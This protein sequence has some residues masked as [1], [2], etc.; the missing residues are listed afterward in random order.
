MTPTLRIPLAALFLSTAGL[1][2]ASEL[3]ACSCTNDHTVLQEFGYAAAVFAGTVTNIQPLGDGNNEI[4]TLTPTVRWKG[5]LDN[6]VQVI[7]G[8]NPAICGFPFAVGQSYLVFAFTSTFSGQPAYW[9]HLCSMDGPLADNP[10]VPALPAPVLP[11]PTRANTWGALK[12][13]Y[14]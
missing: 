11:V 14:R 12:S 5:G 3:R 4:V 10:I 7:T 2:P 6:P 9:T 8:L 13:F 1:L